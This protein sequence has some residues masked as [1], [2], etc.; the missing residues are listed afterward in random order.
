VRDLPTLNARL[1]ALDELLRDEAMF[2]SL[3]Q[4]LTKLPKVR[5]ASGYR[6]SCHDVLTCS[7]DRQDCNRI[8]SQARAAPCFA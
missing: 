8:I 1:D 7:G 6:C 3:A 2:V 4:I 5:L